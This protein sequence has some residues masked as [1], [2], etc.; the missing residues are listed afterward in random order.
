V[1]RHCR[2]RGN[3][4]ASLYRINNVRML[5]RMQVSE[6]INANTCIGVFPFPL[7]NSPTPRTRKMPQKCYQDWVARHI[8][9]ALVKS[10]VCAFASRAVTCL[11]AVLNA[12]AQQLDIALITAFGGSFGYRRFKQSSSIHKI[13]RCRSIY[14]YRIARDLTQ[15]RATEKC[16]LPDMSPNLSLRFEHIQGGSQ[17]CSAAPYQNR[18]LSFGRHSISWRKPCG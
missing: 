18:H 11:P 12:L 7:P 13:E 14:Q 16:T 2:L 9:Q 5:I 6:F 10:I 8:G 15:G 4:I 17:G 3:P 1:R